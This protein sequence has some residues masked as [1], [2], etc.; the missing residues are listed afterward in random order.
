[1]T[2]GKVTIREEDAT[3]LSLGV[4]A[5]MDNVCLKVIVQSFSLKIILCMKFKMV[6][7]L[8]SFI[9]CTLFFQDLLGDFFKDENI[10]GSRG[11]DMCHGHEKYKKNVFF[12]NTMILLLQ[13]YKINRWDNIEKDRTNIYPDNLV[14]F[15]KTN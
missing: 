10:E 5:G 15:K 12:P 9:T 3:S 13:Q 4:P 6:F 1:M 8:L 7:F 11:C 14:N 2:C